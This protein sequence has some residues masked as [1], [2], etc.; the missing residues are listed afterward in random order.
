M[1]QPISQ[2]LP[3]PPP[4]SPLAIYTF[5]LYIC[6]SI[7]A[8]QIGSSIT[9]AQWVKNLPLMQEIRVQSLGWEDPLE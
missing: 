9:M 2:F 7:F 4:T 1:G 3:P 6:V 5:V 8:L